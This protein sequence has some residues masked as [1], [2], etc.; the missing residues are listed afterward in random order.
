MLYTLHTDEA[1]LARLLSE[2]NGHI[3]R[4][5]E[6]LS[7]D[8]VADPAAEVVYIEPL[9]ADRFELLLSSEQV[10]ETVVV[11][12]R[13]RQS[14]S[15]CSFM[16]AV[17]DSDLMEAA[18]AA[19]RRVFEIMKALPHFQLLRIW[20]LI[21]RI[22]EG[23]NEQERYR[24]FNRGRYAAWHEAGPLD[25]TGEP[26]LPAATGIGA[27]GGPLMIQ[28]LMTRKPVRHVQNY[29]QIPS[30]RY[31]EKFGIKPPIFARGTLLETPGAQLIVSGTASV[32]G[33]ETRHTTAAAQTTETVRNLRA[34]LSRRNL[35]NA[36]FA[37]RQFHSV[38]AYVKHTS[39][40]PAIRRELERYISPNEIIYLKD[41]ICRPGL[42]L[43]VE[44]IA[45]EKT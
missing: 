18:L 5:T 7:K 27:W 33:E 4:T 44:G 42:L 16:V 43:E 32:V 17:S 15:F 6:F 29:R 41:D 11:G 19:Y 31:S 40:L 24:L 30:A 39:D 25:P 38:R 37:L 36:E 20:N 2:Y 3:F 28:V 34:L 13:I 26:V 14:E 1:G 22:L 35:G 9:L 45:R 8:K 12:T 10:G 21:P 23:A